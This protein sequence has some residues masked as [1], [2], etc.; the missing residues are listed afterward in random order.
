[1]LL[2]LLFF[3]VVIGPRKEQ[4]QTT[5]QHNNNNNNNTTFLIYVLCSMFFVSPNTKDEKVFQKRNGKDYVILMIIILQH[6]CRLLHTIKS[7]TLLDFHINEINAFGFA[8]SSGV[9]QGR[10][11]SSGL[12]YKIRSLVVSLRFTLLGCS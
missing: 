7:S 8:L 11:R 1:V 4:Q 12:E 2:L 6:W 3:S 5:Q 9:K 10:E